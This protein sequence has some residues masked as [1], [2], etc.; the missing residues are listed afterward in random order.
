MTTPMPA[1]AQTTHR[2]PRDPAPSP[3]C[4]PPGGADPAVAATAMSMSGADRDVPIRGPADGSAWGDVD[5]PG[6]SPT[7]I[8]G[9]SES[10]APARPDAG[11]GAM[12]GSAGP[13]RTDATAAPSGSARRT[14]LS[15]A[16]SSAGV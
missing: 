9:G 4:A 8:V 2:R 7:A 6:M 16:T 13:M 10:P 5:S 11:G 1:A 12:G 3:G 14:A 15:A